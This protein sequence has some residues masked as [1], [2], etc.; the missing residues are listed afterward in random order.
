MSEEEMSKDWLFSDQEQD[1][2]EC[3]KNNTTI[4]TPFD[5]IYSLYYCGNEPCAL[6]TS[7]DLDNRFG[8]ITF[9]PSEMIK[10]A[11]ARILDLSWYSGLESNQPLLISKIVCGVLTRYKFKDLICPESEKSKYPLGYHF[12]VKDIICSSAL[13]IIFEMSD[14]SLWMLHVSSMKLEKFEVTFRHQIEAIGAGVMSQNIVVVPSSSKSNSTRQALIIGDQ[15]SV[16]SINLT[17]TNSPVKLVSQYAFELII[18]VHQDNKIYIYYC[19]S[20]YNYDTDGCGFIVPASNTM[21]YVKTQLEDMCPISQIACGYSHVVL[22]LENGDCFCRGL[23]N[24]NQCLKDSIKSVDEFI[25]FKDITEP[26]RSISCCSICSILTCDNKFH[27]FGEIS[28]FPSTGTMERAFPDQEVAAAAWHCFI[29]RNTF[30]KTSRDQLY[31][32]NN[33][34]LFGRSNSE[35]SRLCDIFIIDQDL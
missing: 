14:L 9:R 10:E 16:D 23:N 13:Q 29:Y 25:R 8:V 6:T 11:S 17:H 7:D 21:I 19:G 32:V 34:K 27:F 28:N 12:E 26:V 3:E 33:M 5:P 4:E 24:F 35:R 18:F 30:H 31:F 15:K 20:D 22:L 2:E 1:L